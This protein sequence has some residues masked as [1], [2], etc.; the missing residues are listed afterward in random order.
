[1]FKYYFLWNVE[2][3]GD[4]VYVWISLSG[5]MYIDWVLCLNIV[6]FVE[7]D[8]GCEGCEGVGVGVI[9]VLFF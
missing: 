2:F 4:G 1:M 5:K 9:I 7:E 6:I 3:L 8:E